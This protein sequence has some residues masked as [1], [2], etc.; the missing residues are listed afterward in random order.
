VW[1]G[2]NWLKTGTSGMHLELVHVKRVYVNRNHRRQTNLWG[3]NYYLKQRKRVMEVISMK[4]T[5]KL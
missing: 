2:V 3:K 5:Q 4:Q 1:T